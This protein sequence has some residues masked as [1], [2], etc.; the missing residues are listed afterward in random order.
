MVSLCVTEGWCFCFWL[1]L[2]FDNW[3]GSVVAL[4]CNLF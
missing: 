2:V 3:L 1:K 4:V